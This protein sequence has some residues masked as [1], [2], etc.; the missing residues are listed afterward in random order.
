MLEKLHCHEVEACNIPFTMLVYVS[1]GV[2]VLDFL[3][4]I[5]KKST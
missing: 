2:F 5:D 1:K 3:F 4:Y